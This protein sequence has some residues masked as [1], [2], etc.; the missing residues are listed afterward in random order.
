MLAADQGFKEVDERFDQAH[1][2]RCNAARSCS[3]AT[4]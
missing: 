4:I 3:A 2:L 1:C